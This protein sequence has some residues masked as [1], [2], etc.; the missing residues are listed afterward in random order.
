MTKTHRESVV[1]RQDPIAGPGL[2]T[3]LAIGTVAVVV[4]LAGRELR[5]ALGL[6]TEVDAIRDWV[7]SFGWRGPVTFVGIVT[8]RQLLFLPAF[9]LLTA[10]GVAFGAAAGTGLGTLGIVGSA[11]MSFAIARAAGREW[12]PQRLRVPLYWLESRG[13]RTGL[14]LVA[15]ATAYPLGPMLASHWAAGFSRLAAPGF[16]ASVAAAAPIRAGILSSFGATLLAWGGVRSTVALLLLL[17]AVLL[18][19]LHPRVRAR[20]GVVTAPST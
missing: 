14:W 8:F 13:D 11:A 18:P 2:P 9:V 7:R 1:A 12:M 6:G 5:D 19:L 3:L 20:L 16:L 4:A 15:L 17:L 10:G